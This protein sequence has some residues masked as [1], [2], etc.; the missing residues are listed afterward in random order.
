MGQSSMTMWRVSLLLLEL[1]IL[2]S[3]KFYNEDG[4]HASRLP[5]Q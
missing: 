5:L 2:N 1:L 4:S 3:T